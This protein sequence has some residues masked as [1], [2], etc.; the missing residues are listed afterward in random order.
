MGSLCCFQLI[1]SMDFVHNFIN[2]SLMEL[3]RI[4][5]LIANSVALLVVGHVNNISRYKIKESMG[6]FIGFQ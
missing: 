6:N 2:E 4:E 3:M 5:V 1:W